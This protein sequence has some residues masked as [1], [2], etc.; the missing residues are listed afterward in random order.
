MAVGIIVACIPTLRPVLFPRRFGSSAQQRYDRTYSDISRKG[1][2]FQQH[3]YE[4][5]SQR[6]HSHMKGL[7]DEIEMEQ[8]LRYGSS[9]TVVAAN[10]H[11]R[12]LSGPGLTFPDRIGV[13][14]DFEVMRAGENS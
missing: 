4:K 11:T 3:G 5:A 13:Q 6:S 12:T 7:E 10:T 2:S 8:P 14:M 9:K 1:L